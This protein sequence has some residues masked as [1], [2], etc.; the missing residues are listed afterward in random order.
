MK[1]KKI[2]SFKHNTIKRMNNE[3]KIFVPKYE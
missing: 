1:V 3:I 2:S